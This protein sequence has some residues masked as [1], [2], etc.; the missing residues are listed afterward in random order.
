MRTAEADRVGD[1][2]GGE[3][4]VAAVVVEP[5]KEA[6]EKLNPFDFEPGTIAIPQG[7]RIRYPSFTHCIAT[8]KVPP[9]TTIAMMT[10]V[11]LVE[12]L[13]KIV[14]NRQG[15]WTWF[16]SD[17]HV[18]DTEE[19]LL[20]LIAR[21]LP[22]VA[23]FMLKRSPP[24]VPVAFASQ[25]EDGYAPVRWNDLPPGGPDENG[26]VAV[27]ACGSGG[28]LIQ[29]WVWDKIEERQGHDRFFEYEAGEIL[30]EDLIL[31][32]KIRDF[33]PE[34]LPIYLDTNNMIGHRATITVW[35]SYSDG[36]WGVGFDMGQD[37]DDNRTT[38]FIPGHVK[39]AG[40]D[41]TE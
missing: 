17:D 5:A 4:A 40:A 30:N 22:V 18:W 6:G 38:I 32:R 9:G 11:S 8:T 19:C 34:A 35:P 33:V 2:T 14:R 12:N 37:V 36:E 31:C 1:G 7:E 21:D 15:A 27:H 39:P 25:H 24:F 10:S 3:G 23:P 16:Q 20:K 41:T 13:N 26:L 28:M 29:N